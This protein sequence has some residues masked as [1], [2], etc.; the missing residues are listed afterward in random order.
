MAIW[1]TV[2]ITLLGCI[3][4][5][6]AG[7]G[8]NGLDHRQA[9]ARL[10][11]PAGSKPP[12]A[13]AHLGS[14]STGTPLANQQV[15]TGIGGNFV[16][17]VYK[18]VSPAVVHITNK[19][20]HKQ[21]SFFFGPQEFETEATGSGVIVDSKGYILTN[22]HVIENAN[23]I[24]VVFSDGGELTAEVVGADPGTDL[25]LLKVQSPDPLPTAPMGD[26]NNLEAGEWV[27]AIGNPRGFDWTVTAGVISALNR[28][29][30]SQRTGQTMRGL[31][32]TDA[33]IN[34]GNSGGPLLNAR[35]EIIG[36]NEIIISTSGG[37]QGIGLAIPINVARDVL[38]DL[39]QY[40]RVIRPWLGVETTRVTPM[41]AARYNF[42]V[43]YGEVIIRAIDPSP[44]RKGGMVSYQSDRTG[45]FQYDIIT[46]VDNENL[47]EE[48]ELLDII[49]DKQDGDS[50]TLDYY[51]ITNGKSEAKRATIRLEAMPE[52]APLSGII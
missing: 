37:S 22:N 9:E 45:F 10:S 25:A 8:L 13:A 28:E 43:D 33:A 51:R 44:A 17:E 24:L 41:M 1:K 21:W 16:S 49:R 20:V 2:T 36:I 34:P 5:I 7:F 15:T 47:D 6:V 31:I 3:A 38:D 46:A 26:S 4:G 40:G 27:V 42:P 30:P 35:G 14:P 50:I 23:E 11:D 32:Q 12:A 48:R 52:N 19:A 29:M 39:V 18:A